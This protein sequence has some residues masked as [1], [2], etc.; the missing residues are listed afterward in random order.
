M[1]WVVS[2]SS[3]VRASA[4][5]W[6]TSPRRSEAQPRWTSTNACAGIEARGPRVGEHLLQAR[7]G[8]VERVRGEQAD[9]EQVEG[10]G[11]VDLL[12]AQ[13]PAARERA[14]DVA[15]PHRVCRLA[16]P[17]PLEGEAR[18]HQA[19]ARRVAREVAVT[20][21]PRRDR[22]R[23]PR[24]WPA[25][26]RPRAPPRAAAPARG[27]RPRRPR[28]PT[29]SPRPPG[30]RPPTR[31]ARS[32]SRR[33]GGREQLRVPDQ[34]GRLRELLDAPPASRGAARRSRA[35][36]AP[37][38][39]TPAAVAPPA[40][41]RATR[42]RRRALPAR[43]RPRPPGAGARPGRGRRPAPPRRS[44]RRSAPR[45][46]RARGEDLGGA[47][48]RLGAVVRA[49]VRV[50][51]FAD[52]RV[53]ELEAARPASGSRARPGGRRR[54]PPLRSEISASRAASAR[55]GAVAEHRDGAHQRG[56]RRRGLRRGAGAP[57]GPPRRAR[58]ACTRAA[59]PESVESFCSHASRRSASRKNGLPPVASR[60][61]AANSGATSA[62]SLRSQSVAVASV[63]S[64]PGRST[65]VSGPAASRARSGVTPSRRFGSRRERRAGGR[66]GAAPGS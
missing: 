4:S 57:P 20:L 1:S 53:C 46:R 65:V 38:P 28:S 22:E 5:A 36:A 49:D 42:P 48:V 15:P 47:R 18:Q 44:G 9:D 41:G 50:D 55:L 12:L 33:D 43:A 17:G 59:S 63:L 8:E 10:A 30:P 60:H 27:P 24:G 14:L 45:R 31:S 39:W 6:A 62:P 40:P 37:L 51:G 19:L 64:G 7:V 2:S 16:G 58:C 23:E 13:Q 54:V 25:A 3:A 56:R 34:L 29:R 26:R 11:D 21:E 52:D 61:A 32:P 35:R 66:P